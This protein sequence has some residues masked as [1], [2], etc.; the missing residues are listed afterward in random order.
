MG[1]VGGTLKLA[2]C[3]EV[4]QECVGEIM[5][6]LGHVGFASQLCHCP[7]TFSQASQF[8]SLDLSCLPSKLKK[9]KRCG[10]QPDNL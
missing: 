2:G 6:G 7:H 4:T 3:G 10:I 5:T 9:I 8:T 1:K